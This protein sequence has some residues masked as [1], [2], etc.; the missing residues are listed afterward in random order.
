MATLMKQPNVRRVAVKSGRSQKTRWPAVLWLA[1]FVS[2]ALG[3]VLAATVLFYVAP[4][5]AEQVR[6]GTYR[7]QQWYGTDW[8]PY[9]NF[10]LLASLILGVVGVVFV[11]GTMLAAGRMKDQAA[12]YWER[13]AL[14]FA[15]TALVF[16]LCVDA[17]MFSV[18]ILP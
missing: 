5:H 9:M 13:V 1:A 2:S 11:V 12:S 16:I 15:A 4:R 7:H 14:G 18:P 3:L 10:G 6:V 17:L 8:N